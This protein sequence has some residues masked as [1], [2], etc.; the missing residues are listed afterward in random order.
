MNMPQNVKCVARLQFGAHLEATMIWTFSCGWPLVTKLTKINVN[1]RCKALQ[2]SPE[3]Y[4]VEQWTVVSGKRWPWNLIEKENSA[5]GNS[6]GPFFSCIFFTINHF[7]VQLLLTFRLPP[8]D[9]VC[10]TYSICYLFCWLCDVDHGM[11]SCDK[12]ASFFIYLKWSQT[13]IDPKT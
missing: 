6:I 3:R 13:G 11:F 2:N 9:H 4:S 12:K 5:V 1:T 7:A 10:H 8:C